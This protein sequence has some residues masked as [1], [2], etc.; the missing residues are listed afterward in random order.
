[1]TPQID[2]AVAYFNQGYNCAQ[3]VAVAYAK[4]LGLDDG[5][6]L[7]MTAGFGGGM[8]GLRET[9]GAVSAMVLI[10]GLRSADYPPNDTAAKQRQ[11]ALVR[12]M[13]QEFTEEHGTTCCRQLLKNASCSFTID[14][15]ERNPEY[16]RKRPCVRFVATAA[17]IVARWL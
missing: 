12:R 11:Y 14:P 10:A 9:C 4:D 16:Y 13:V 6:M 3:S 5:M 7:K 15:S 1:M 17:T 2:K 8:G